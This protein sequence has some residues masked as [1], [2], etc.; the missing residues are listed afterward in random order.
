MESGARYGRLPEELSTSD[1]SAHDR[2]YSSS[3]D[4]DGSGLSPGLSWWHASRRPYRFAVLALTIMLSFGSHYCFDAPSV[5]EKALLTVSTA[6]VPRPDTARH[7][8]HRV[9][10]GPC[11][12]PCVCAHMLGSAPALRTGPHG[13]APTHTHSTGPL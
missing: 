4:D 11:A 9:P 10:R 6:P 1:D 13:L 5:L 8:P 7:R 3:S 12:G 2:L